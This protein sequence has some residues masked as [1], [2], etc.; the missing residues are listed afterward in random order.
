[1]SE[2]RIYEPGWKDRRWEKSLRRLPQD[3]R[4]HLNA[5]LV[6]LAGDLMECRHPH[7]DPRMQRWHPTRWNAPR[8]QKRHG[9][10][11][12]FRLGDRKNKARVIICHDARNQVIYLAARTAIH[13]LDRLQRVVGGFS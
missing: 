3:Q 11:Y 2:V 4:D 12:E 7:L 1:M 10:W 9:D 5:A 6:E 8:L 13:D